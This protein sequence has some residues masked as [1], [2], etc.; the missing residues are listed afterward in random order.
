MATVTE[1]GPRL[2]I[3]PTCAALALPRATYYR[4]RRSQSAPPARPPSP[5]AL[6]DA[7][8][9]AV[10]TVLHEPRFVDL[11]PAIEEASSIPI[12]PA[13]RSLTP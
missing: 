8:R 4:W 1:V 11:A 6:S 12:L 5:R 13:R 3:A 10:L 7:E 2:G 9:A